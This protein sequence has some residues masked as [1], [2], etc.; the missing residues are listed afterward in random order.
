VVKAEDSLPRG[1][2]FKPPT[3][4]TIFQAPFICIKAWNK[5]CGKLKPGIV[6]CAVIPQVDFEEWSVYKIQLHGT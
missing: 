5:N 4:Q 2:G 6:A 1:P 3:M